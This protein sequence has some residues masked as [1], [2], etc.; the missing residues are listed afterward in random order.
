MSKKHITYL[1]LITNL[2]SA[3]IA[4]LIR[5]VFLITLTIITGR[6]ILMDD[7][8]PVFLVRKGVINSRNLRAEGG[9][10]R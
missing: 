5:I 2:L 7:D 9:V 6:A 1:Y 3:T 8:S 4:S 10:R